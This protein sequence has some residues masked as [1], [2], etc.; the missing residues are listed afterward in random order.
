MVES[1]QRVWPLNW[2]PLLCEK[3]MALMV[4]QK[5][6]LCWD[7]VCWPFFRSYGWKQ[8][9]LFFFFFLYV[10]VEIL[11]GWGWR[12]FGIPPYFGYCFGLQLLQNSQDSSLCDLFHDFRLQFAS[13]NYLGVFF[14]LADCWSQ[15][16]SNL[17]RVDLCFPLCLS[18]LDIF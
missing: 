14:W 5:L 1:V 4:E 13:L 8:V 3:P 18:M 9:E 6:N 15:L 10:C 2:Y 7:A 16:S 11:V 12:R 17:D